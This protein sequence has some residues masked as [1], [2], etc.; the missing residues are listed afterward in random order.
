MPTTFG[1]AADLPIEPF[2]GLLDQI[3][4][5]A[6]FGNAVK[7][8]MSGS[9]GVEVLRDGWQLVGQCVED[10]VELG[11]HRVG[12]GLVVDRVQQRL[13]PAPGILRGGGH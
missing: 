4:R 6:A 10:A 9:G 13:D 8:K 5:H 3:C 12:V 2:L 1:A 7:A 11:V